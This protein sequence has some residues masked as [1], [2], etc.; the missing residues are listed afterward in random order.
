MI[1]NQRVARSLAAV[2]VVLVALAGVGCGGSRTDAA[3]TRP[4]ASGS[5]S[6]PEAAPA[7]PVV[8]RNPDGTEVR[9]DD[10][11]RLVVL[12]GDIAEVVFALGLGDHVVATD[13]SATYP[14]EADALPEI[15][16][17]RSLN[18]EGILAQQP[19]AILA[20]ADAGPP[21][22]IEQ[23]RA[24]GIPVAVVPNPHDINAPIVKI[25]AVAT[26]LGIP[27]RGDA[28]AR[29]VQTQLDELEAVRT[30]VQARPRVA[31]LYLRGS[32]TQLL[33]GRDQGAD[34]IADAAGGLPAVST[35][36][37]SPLT[38]EALVAA[39]PDVIVLT[40]GGLASVG[41]IDGVL[42]IPGVAETPAGRA[43]RVF[44]YDDQMLLGFGPRFPQVLRA[45][46]SD[47]HPDQVLVPG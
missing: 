41:G 35:D 27:A 47:L 10:V 20:T 13:M 18:A 9:I 8:H 25:R 28:L 33:F 29:D 39:A 14:P 44:A 17:Q 15:G 21:N 7:L 34:A 37:T 30:T 42:A 4:P 6:A 38:P 32:N 24:A 19:T 22:V 23:V 40:T 26:A 16:Y 3:T 5:I 11:S 2:V 1:R 43:R 36:A 45:L 31:L 46:F 12:N